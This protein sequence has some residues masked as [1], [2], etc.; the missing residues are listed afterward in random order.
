M[1]AQYLCSSIIVEA[2]FIGTVQIHL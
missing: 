2:F 1:P